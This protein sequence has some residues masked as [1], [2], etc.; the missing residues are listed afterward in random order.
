MLSF[1]CHILIIQIFAAEIVY[2]ITFA[3]KTSWSMARSLWMD[4]PNK[5]HHCDWLSHKPLITNSQQKANKKPYDLLCWSLSCYFLKLYSLDNPWYL[6]SC[7]IVHLVRFE[8]IKREFLSGYGIMRN[9]QGAEDAL[10]VR[11]S[12][13]IHTRRFNYNTANFSK[14][15][16]GIT[17]APRRTYSRGISSSSNPLHRETVLDNSEFAAMSTPV[18]LGI[19]T[20]AIPALTDLFVPWQVRAYSQAAA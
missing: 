18:F 10:I 20:P 8:F 12:L 16:H 1:C 5:Q 13:P 19:W 11:L 9:I 14:K 6:F 7:S 4:L 2:F 15:W 17:R 3:E